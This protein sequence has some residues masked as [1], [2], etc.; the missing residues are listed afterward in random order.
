MK[1][2]DTLGSEIYF[3]YIHG[4]DK[5]NAN[6]VAGEESFEPKWNYMVMKYEQK[7]LRLALFPEQKI[8]NHWANNINE[9]QNQPSASSHSLAQVVQ[10]IIFREIMIS[11]RS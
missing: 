8:E 9:G 1:R 7:E 2:T 6:V 5:K 11:N 3:Y 10:R 4:E